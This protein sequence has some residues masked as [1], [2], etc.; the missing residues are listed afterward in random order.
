M[1]GLLVFFVIFTAG[2]L[3]LSRPRVAAAQGAIPGITEGGRPMM[4]PMSGG[5]ASIAA[6]DGS[7]Y[8]VQGNNLYRFDAKTLAVQAKTNLVPPAPKPTGT[9]SSGVPGE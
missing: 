6:Y 2:V 4:P 3:V 1:V 8:V 5:A 9:Q 7:V